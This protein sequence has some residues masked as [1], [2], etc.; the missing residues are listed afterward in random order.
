MFAARMRQGL[1]AA[2]VAIGLDVFDELLETEVT[3]LAGA[4]GK[5]D[6]DRSHNRH[7]SVDGSLQLL[8]PNVLSPFH[9]AR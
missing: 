8:P 2:S 7:G 4:K 5:H 6:A 1:L 9:P 3:G